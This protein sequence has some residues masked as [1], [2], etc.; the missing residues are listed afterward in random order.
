MRTT[1][2]QEDRG[3][4]LH[5]RQAEYTRRE[6]SGGEPPKL[7]C[8]LR[9][10]KPNRKPRTPFTT[11][12]LLS[13]EKK[14]REKQYLSIAGA[15]R[16]LLVAA[17]HRDA[18]Q[19]LVPEPT[20]QGQAPAE[21]E[22]EKLKMR[23]WG[24]AAAAPVRPAGPA[25]VSTRTPTPP[26]LPPPRR[27]VGAAGP[28]P[29][30]AAAAPPAPRPPPPPRSAPAGRW[31]AAVRRPRDLARP[32]LQEWGS[33]NCRTAPRPVSVGDRHGNRAA[34]LAELRGCAQTCCVRRVVTAGLLCRI[35][36]SAD[37]LDREPLKTARLCYGPTVFDVS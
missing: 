29:R 9:K 31:R 22:I 35:D 26:P 33:R 1:H 13:L 23:R 14:F 30:G 11:Q 19:D 10:H 37:G 2:G 6:S 34:G 32:R 21:A 12:Q 3:E 36:V 16:V 28:P 4:Q 15:R 25:A 5:N 8:N 24:G 20:R 7:K 27:R 17:P 18:G